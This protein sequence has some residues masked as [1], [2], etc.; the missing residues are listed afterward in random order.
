M[1]DGRRTSEH[2]SDAWTITSLS[3]I[4][5]RPLNSISR[6][7][8]QI[9][10]LPSTTTIPTFITGTSSTTPCS[11]PKIPSLAWPRPLLM[12]LCHQQATL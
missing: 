9:L 8:T 4:F 10:F 3:G 11:I 7:Q 5:P 6:P 1:S 12:I 2:S